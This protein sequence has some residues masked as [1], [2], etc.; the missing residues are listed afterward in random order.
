M[1]AGVL[2]HTGLNYCLKYVSPLLISISVTLE[3][4]LGSLIGWMFFSTGIPGLWTWIGGP[5]LMVGIISIVYGEHLAS[6]VKEPLAKQPPASRPE[7]VVLNRSQLS[8]NKQQTETSDKTFT[9][10]TSIDNTYRLEVDE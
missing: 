6:N 2:G 8:R 1:I 7:S 5:I 9:K 10:Q 3:P 4:V